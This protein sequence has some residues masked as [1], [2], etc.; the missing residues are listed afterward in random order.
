MLISSRPARRNPLIGNYKN[1][2]LAKAPVHDIKHSVLLL[3]R[4]FLSL[5]WE[6]TTVE[7]IRAHVSTAACDICIGAASSVP[8]IGHK[9][10]RPVNGL[11]MHGLPDGAALG[12]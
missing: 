2:S 9:R 7:N 10:V 5:G 8:L 3:R 11:H 12:V 1:S 6:Q 4:L